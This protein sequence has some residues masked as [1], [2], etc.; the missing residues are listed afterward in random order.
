MLYLQYKPSS[1]V[2][3]DSLLFMTW[4][5]L[6]G[7][8]LIGVNRPAVGGTVPHFHQMSREMRQMF[9]ILRKLYYFFPILII[10]HFCLGTQQSDDFPIKL[11]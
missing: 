7:I 11:G 1:R 6:P 2:F 5:L 4:R 9:R 10:L 3:P 8:A